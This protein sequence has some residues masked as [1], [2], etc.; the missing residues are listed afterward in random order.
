MLLAHTTSLR[1]MLLAELLTND[2]RSVNGDLHLR[3]KFDAENP[4]EE[5][6]VEAPKKYNDDGEEIDEGGK[7][8][9]EEEPT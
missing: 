7:V 6:P 9:E 3:F 2:L 8:I 4:T 1:V 5:E